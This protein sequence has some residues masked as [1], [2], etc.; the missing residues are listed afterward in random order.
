MNEITPEV[1]AARQALREALMKREQAK[2]ELL[3]AVRRLREALDQ[4]P[5]VSMFH[6][7]QAG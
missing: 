2:T 3:R 6:K 1:L 4:R 5:P 7:R